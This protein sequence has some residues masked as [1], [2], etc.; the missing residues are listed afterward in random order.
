MGEMFRVRSALDRAFSLPVRSPRV[1]LAES[2]KSSPPLL[3]CLRRRCP[4]PSYL[5]VRTS[6]RIACPPFDSA[7][8]VGLQ[9]DAEL[10]HVQ[11]HGHGRNVLRALR[12]YPGPQPSVGPSPCTPLSPP[13]PP[14]PL[15]GRTV[16]ARA[17]ATPASLPGTSPLIVYSP[18]DSAGSV[19]LQQAAELRHDQRHGHEL[20]VL[21]ALRACPGPPS[22][23]QLSPV[24][25]CRLR[26]QCPTPSR[27]AVR[28]SPRIVYSPVD[29]AESVG[30][31][32]AAELGHVQR[33]THGPHVQSALRACP[34]LPAFSRAEPCMPLEPPSPHFLSPPDPHPAP[35]RMHALLST[36][37]GALAFDQPLSLDTSSV[38]RMDH[39]FR[40]RSARALGSQPSV[41][42]SPACRLSHLRP[43]SSRLPTRTPPRI[44]CMPSF[45]L[46]RARW[47]ST[48]R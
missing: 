12:A 36:R 13:S 30:L 41:G 3:R 11:R 37:Q 8:S 18:F 21:R 10:R 2:Q 7:G 32:P 14:R 23:L 45:R 16:A 19:G 47:R 17:G 25:A 4:T 28:T 33:H 40:V 26:R 20:H 44:A 6:P 48:S 39:M 31:Q 46:G 27:L 29:S 43:T 24:R 35:H 22:L 42:P 1:L 15:P 5:S 34:G 38:T 9:Q